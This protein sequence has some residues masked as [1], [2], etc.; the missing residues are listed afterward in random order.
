MMYT[1]LCACMFLR[2][3]LSLLD[4]LS[5]TLGQLFSL[6][7]CTL[8]HEGNETGGLGGALPP[9]PKELLQWLLCKMYYVS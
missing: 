7:T 8:V 6:F 2:C 5:L 9:S 4:K 1:C 3:S